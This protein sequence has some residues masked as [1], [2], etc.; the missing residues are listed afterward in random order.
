MSTRSATRR[1]WWGWASTSS[2]STPTSPTTISAR[3]RC[4]VRCTSDASAGRSCSRAAWWSTAKGGTDA[5]STASF[6]P[7]RG[8]SRTS[9]SGGSSRGV[10]RAV[11]P[12]PPR[13]SPRRHRSIRATSTPPRRCIRSICAPPTRV[14]TAVRWRR[15]ATTTSTVLACPGT[16]R[17][18]AWRASSGA[19]SSEAMRR[20]C[21]RTDARCGTSCTSATSPTPTCGR[22]SRAPTARSTSRARR[23][24]PWERWRRRSPAP[25]APVLL[26]H[27]SSGGYR[28]G[29]VRHVFASP[30]KA[31]R[32]LGFRST[33]G[34]EDGMRAFARDPL[35][36]PQIVASRTPAATSPS[37]SAATASR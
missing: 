34:F 32:E 14:S 30:A 35:R 37:T 19:P 33:V 4:S 28:L 31:R 21:S 6:A 18:R 24:T 16:R 26:V 7:G 36:A 23:R 27:G 2:T 9:S 20:R 11:R 8:A 17:T 15:C 29:D 22:W 10:P 13:R 5:T 25:S 3:R 12:W 1:R